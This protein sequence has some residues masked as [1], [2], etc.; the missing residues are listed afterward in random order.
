MLCHRPADCDAVAAR[1]RRGHGSSR[2]TPIAG[3]PA[4]HLDLMDW[5][6]ELEDASPGQSTVSYMLGVHAGTTALNSDPLDRRVAHSL[7]ALSMMSRLEVAVATSLLRP[8]RISAEAYATLLPGLVTVPIAR[9]T[10]ES[11]VTGRK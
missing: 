4:V 2:A 11:V 8:S 7:F 9:S 5:L 6:Q 1:P 10:P 3:T